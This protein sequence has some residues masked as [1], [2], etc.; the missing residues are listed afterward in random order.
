MLPLKVT[1][2]SI[3]PA[4]PLTGG[5]ALTWKIAARRGKP[6]LIVEPGDAA[7]PETIRRWL[8]EQEV[9]ILNV[10]GPRESGHRGIHGQAL[11]LLRQAF[12]G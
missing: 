3:S 8:A 12:E 10:A 7:A 4:A 1:P 2:Y 11:A 5:T 6:C 9:R